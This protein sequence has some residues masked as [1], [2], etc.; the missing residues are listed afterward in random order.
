MKKVL[1]AIIK[2]SAV[3]ILLLM[4]I[5]S[6]FNHNTSVVHG[7]TCPGQGKS[8]DPPIEY[9]GHWSPCWTCAGQRELYLDTQAEAQAER[10][11]TWGY[12]VRS[13]KDNK[14]DTWTCYYRC[15]NCGVCDEYS[16]LVFKIKNDS[17]MERVEGSGSRASGIVPWYECRLCTGKRCAN[18]NFPHDAV[19]DTP[20]PTPFPTATP[21][22]TPT[23]INTPVPVPNKYYLSIDSSPSGSCTTSGSGYYSAGEEVTVSVTSVSTGYKWKQW[24]YNGTTKAH[25]NFVIIMTDSDLSILAVC[26]AKDPLNTPA[27][28]DTP[29][30]IITYPPA[31]SIPTYK[32][33]TKVSPAGAGRVT[34]GK[35]YRKDATPQI[36]A[37]PYSGYLFSHWIISPDIPLNAAGNSKNNS[38]TMPAQGVTV[39][40]H[41]VTPTPTPTTAPTPTPTPYTDIHD[42]RCYLGTM[43]THGTGCTGG[44]DTTTCTAGCT[45][46]RHTGNQYSGTGCY[47]GKYHEGEPACGGTLSV[48]SYTSS[49]EEVKIWDNCRSCYQYVYGTEY[50][51][52]YEEICSVCG[53]IGSTSDYYF[54]C[55]E[56]SY[57]YYWHKKEENEG[58]YHDSGTEGYYEVGCGLTGKYCL[59]GVLCPT[60]GGDKEVSAGCSLIEN[61]FYYNGVLDTP[62][63]HL[64]VTS[65]EPKAPVQTIQPGEIPNV[66]ATATFYLATHG[67]CPPQT[68]TC[69][70]TGFNPNLYNTVQTVTL[71]Y[72]Q[73][74]DSAKSAGAKTVTIQ[75][76][77]DGNYDMH[78]DAGEGTLTGADYHVVTLGSSNYYNLSTEIPT[79]P[80]GY[81]FSGWYTQ[82]SGGSQ[83]YN[84]AGVCNN[85]G[86]YWKNNLWQYKGDVTF[87]AGYNP[88]T[89][90]VTFNASPGTVSPATKTVT[91]GQNYGEL[92]T[93]NPPAGYKWTGKWLLSTDTRVVITSGTEIDIAEN[94][95]LIAEYAPTS[96]LVTYNANGGSI[97]EN[98]SSTVNKS[99]TYNSTYPSVGTT[100]PGYDFNG[101]YLDNMPLPSTVNK[102]SAHTVYAWWSPKT[103]TITWNPNGGSVSNSSSTVKMDSTFNNNYTPDASKAGHEL[104]GWWTAPS[105]GT[106]IYNSDKTYVGG[107]ACWNTSGQWIY[108]NNITL[109]VQWSPKTYTV[110]LDG[111]GATAQTQTSVNIVYNTKSGNITVPTR[112]GYIFQGYYAQPNGIG[113]QYY[114]SNGE[115]IIVWPFAQ[116]GTVYAYWKPITYI[117]QYHGNGATAGG[118]YGSEHTYDVEQKLNTNGFSLTHTVFYQDCLDNGSTSV[119]WVEA[120]GTKHTTANGTFAGWSTT[121]N[122]SV[123]YTNGQSVKNLASTQGAVV[124]LYAKWNVGTVTLPKVTREGYI[125]QGWNTAP[126]G[127]GT[128]YAQGGT[129]TPAGDDYLYGIWKAG[130]YTV[131]L[132]ANGGSVSPTSK[133]VTFDGTYGEL[134]IPTRAGYE[135]VGWYTG[136]STGAEVTSG[137]SMTTPANHTIYAHWKA[138]NYTV[139]LDYNGGIKGSGDSSPYTMTFDTANYSDISWGLPTR[140]GY[141]FAGWWTAASGGTQ[142]YDASGICTKEGI[143][144]NT[145]GF[146]IYLGNVTLYAKWIPKK[147]D[148]TLN[149]RGATSTDHTESVVM[150][151]EKREPDIIVPT[152]TGYTFHGYY[153]ETRGKGTQYYDES[154]ISIKTW[155]EDDKNTLYAYW[156]QNPVILPEEEDTIVPTPV[157]EKDVT[158]RIGRND[159]TALLYADDYNLATNALTDLQPYLTYDTPGMEGAIPGTEMISLRA[160]MGSWMLSYKFH[161]S[162][163][164]DYVRIYVTVPYR[165]Q[166]EL[167]NEE[168]VISGQQTKTYTYSIPKVWSYWEIMESGMYYLRRIQVNNDALKNGSIE[169]EVDWSGDDAVTHPVYDVINYGEKENHVFWAEYDADGVPVLR[170][171]LTE[172]QYLISETVGSLPDIDSHLNIV[173]KNAAWKDE[174]QAEVRSDRYEFDG[175][176]VL[177]DELAQNGEGKELEEENLP[178]NNSVVGM[179]AYQQTYKSG[180][181]LE[182]YKPNGTYDTTVTIFYDGDPAN[183][184]SAATKTERITDVNPLKLHTPVA[185]KGVVVDGM[186]ETEDSAVLILDEALNFFTLRIDNTGTHRRNLGYGTKDFARA[187]S[188]KSNIAKEGDACLNQVQFPFD[189]YVDTESNSLQA[190][191]SYD[192]TGDLYVEAG[193]WVTMG[194]SEL[195]FYVPVMVENGIRQIKFRTI[196]VNCPEN[197]EG[198]YI[199]SGL[200]QESV[201]T[202]PDCYIATDSIYVAINSYL[203]DFRITDTNDSL[204]KKQLLSGCQALT[205]KKG[206]GFWFE[207]LTQGEFYGEDTELEIVPR[208]YWV[209][210]TEESRTEVQLY[211]EDILRGEEKEYYE[212]E[213]PPLQK[214]ENAD[215]I[216]QRWT[217]SGFIPADVVCLA[218]DDIEG[219]LIVNFEIKVKSNDDVWYTFEGWE[220]TELA[221]DAAEV[222]WNYVPGDVIRYDLSKSIADDYEIGGME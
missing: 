192:T 8:N 61:A 58:E 162:S 45:L 84:A 18:W 78:L 121:P 215:V 74:N 16:E 142:V 43:H 218:A 55:P 52:N 202:N 13:E 4:I 32:V 140:V 59:N 165:T 171:T 90:L 148:I 69:E 144:F 168:L 1:S 107:T 196:A 113:S 6:Y 176:T 34:G 49:D 12:Q 203:K 73:Y 167:D 97:T 208:F 39:T 33:T 172:E 205:L 88:K 110:T 24:S 41:F 11:G 146:W 129:Y 103:Y 35:W 185:C 47:T 125:F 30:P 72:G 174:R 181:E 158:G 95:T 187:L 80:Y 79:L 132:K 54:V 104:T 154:G 76:T 136:A 135:F 20:T 222:G 163:G 207:F 115:N 81:D 179:T 42:D 178:K 26:E 210:K 166:Y 5:V 53:V 91:F 155:T 191:G 195:R 68:V 152:K 99:V 75:V 112:T 96:I 29:T 122:G 15:K 106:K 82:P 217:G 71:S 206:Y 157:P 159:G 117:I 70:Y 9:G 119:T 23:P 134:P 48:G 77:I 51:D 201:N 67:A 190:D 21:T 188:G 3:P 38:F 108:T 198:G 92:P 197:V 63:C 139:T 200:E 153:T 169:I 60:C 182:E 114:N 193:T 100:R 28:S 64:V 98:G 94:H 2:Y 36:K 173:C 160:K 46:H 124:P 143:Y 22:I 86:T 109:Y 151:F 56:C 66:T 89:P 220:S 194:K 44:T 137:T 161:R 31:T 127:T 17:S 164:T 123:V 14:G 50:I 65:L 212:M 128:S 183:V 133:A 216:F 116:N 130:S 118:T 213:L 40:A 25:Q 10:R 57:T 111:Q 209:S 7:A 126:D 145:N 131:T 150:T 141:D 87:Y 189:V 147:Y 93:P 85:E 156:T 102:T 138:N 170:I 199:I 27:P 175:K 204:A 37:Y 19:P 180:I 219:Y 214:E 120:L 149:D 101:W 184:G 211:Q 177:S 62:L 221:Q 105:G 186:E 83:I